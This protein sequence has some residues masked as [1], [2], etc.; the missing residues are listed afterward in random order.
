M[1]AYGKV[2]CP[3]HY[4]QML[5]Y[6]HPLDSIQ[7][8]I[9]DLN[10][11][12]IDREHNIAMIRLYRR[13]STYI[14]S[15]IVDLEDI[16]RLIIYK[17]RYWKGRV[18]TGN[19]RPI[20][21]SYK[22]LGIEENSGFVIDYRNSNPLDN[23]KENLRITS[24]KENII[25]KKILAN[26]SSGFTGL[27]FDDSR[28]KWCAEIKKNGIKCF[29]GRHN[30]LCDAVYARYLGELW[31]FGEFRSETNDIQI[32]KEIQKCTDRDRI[33]SYVKKRLLERYEIN[34]E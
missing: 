14:T 8:T 30:K 2:L 17:W 1:H 32:E 18:Y 9:K 29:L 11:F 4:Q 24:Q 10:D 19:F 13:D 27:Y 15:A 34:I 28:N 3:K 31:L 23:R 33:E 21:L 16:P 7:R 5:K 20:Q 12:E 6:G 26:N 25:N 22:V